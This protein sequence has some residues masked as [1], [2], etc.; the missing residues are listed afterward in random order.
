MPIDKVAHTKR[1]IHAPNWHDD[2]YIGV[3]PAGSS[4][5]EIAY[6]PDRGGCGDG[7]RVF[8]PI[9]CV[10]LVSAALIECGEEQLELLGIESE[11]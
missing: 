10:S 8:I 9:E 11:E 1:R 7:G 4:G 2:H 5:V 6:V 3:E